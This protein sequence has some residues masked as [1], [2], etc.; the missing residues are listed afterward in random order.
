[1]VKVTDYFRL[2]LLILINT[3]ATY[4]NVHIFTS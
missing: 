4:S 3:S 2:A 1:M